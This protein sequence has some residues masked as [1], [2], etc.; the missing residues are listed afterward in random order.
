MRLETENLVVPEEAR[1]EDLVRV[2]GDDAMRGGFIILTSDDGSILQAAGKGWSPYTLEFFP[3][4]D[5]TRYVQA[6]TQLDKDQV[7]AAFI[8]FLHKG[9]AWR[10]SLTWREL[11]EKKGCLPALFASG[12]VVSFVLGY[13]LLSR[14]V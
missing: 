2:F 10:S 5:A 1:E 3:K 14:G 8:D 4:K 13:Y 12:A 9:T 7:R 6:T 11:D